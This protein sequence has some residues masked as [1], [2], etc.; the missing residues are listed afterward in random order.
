MKKF[1]V[2]LAVTALGLTG[3]GLSFADG[4]MDSLGSTKT[5]EAPKAAAL[6]YNDLRL[7]GYTDANGKIV[8]MKKN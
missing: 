2:S 4:S 3:G 8:W 6:N 5:K 7:S 1:L